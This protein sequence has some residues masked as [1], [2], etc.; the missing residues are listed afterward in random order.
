MIPYLLSLIL[1]IA[2]TVGF[3][4]LIIFL[5]RFIRKRKGHEKPYHLFPRFS[6]RGKLP[7]LKK[8]LAITGYIFLLLSSTLF[9]YNMANKI[10]FY[11]I[12]DGYAE[13]RESNGQQYLYVEADD[14]YSLGY[15]KGEYMAS[16]IAYINLASY[17]MLQY[18]GENYRTYANN[19]LSYIPDEYIE[20][21]QGM[22]DGATHGFGFPITFEDILVENCFLDLLYGQVYPLSAGGTVMGC[23]AIGANNSDG[24]ITMGQNFDLNPLAE[25]GLTYVHYKITGKA[26]VFC[27]HLG[28]LKLPIAKNSNNVSTVANVIGSKLVGEFTVPSCI[29]TQYCLETATNAT[30]AYNLFASLAKR[31]AAYNLMVCDENELIAVQNLPH[32]YRLRSGNPIVQSNR[33]VYSDWN[34][35]YF[36]WGDYSTNRQYR[37]ELEANNSFID[38]YLTNQELLTIL[39]LKEEYNNLEDSE[40][41]RTSGRSNTLAFITR[42]SFG[43]GTVHDGVGEL[44]I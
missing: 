17:L 15:L 19:Y 7:R 30:H 32:D 41:C 22:A 4:L 40:I 34:E 10:T 16:K 37:A 29:F 26:E 13:W 9:L 38:N 5:Y 44:P 2:L 39:G 33:F 24:T 18:N 25:H 23:T 20:Q 28:A 31:P 12:V 21:M 3:W 35:D 43:I 8:G 11:R 36:L 1:G 42:E 14:Y 6:F 27:L